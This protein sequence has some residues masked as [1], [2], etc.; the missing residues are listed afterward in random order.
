MHR[1][2]FLQMSH[3][4]GGLMASW[5][6]GL[7]WTG[8]CRFICL[9]GVAL[10]RRII[11]PSLWPSTI[12]ELQHVFVCHGHGLAD[13]LLLK[14][15]WDDGDLEVAHGRSLDLVVGASFGDKIVS[16]YVVE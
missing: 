1:F 7:C 4:Q 10:L 13:A 8:C 12:I 6:C 14:N 5:F 9:R 3:V 16:P 15:S 2:P 11:S